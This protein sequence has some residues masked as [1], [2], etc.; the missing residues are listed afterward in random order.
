MSSTS[1]SIGLQ[2]I[3]YFWPVVYIYIYIYIYILKYTLLKCTWHAGDLRVET[4]ENISQVSLQCPLSWNYAETHKSSFICLSVDST[5]RYIYCG[6]ITPYCVMGINIILLTLSFGIS[7]DV[8]AFRC[9][10]IIG[11]MCSV[12]W[13]KTSTLRIKAHILITNGWNSLKLINNQ[14]LV[15]F[16]KCNYSPCKIYDIVEMKRHYYFTQNG[17]RAPYVGKMPIPWAKKPTPGYLAR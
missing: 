5:Q 14:T 13:G 16:L 2:N 10:G 4:I 11:L 15:K 1:V 6:L 12:T 3:P 7:H 17:R 8:E 9:L